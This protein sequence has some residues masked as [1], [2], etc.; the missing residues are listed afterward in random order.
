MDIVVDS[1]QGDGMLLIDAAICTP[2]AHSYL[3]AAQERGGAAGMRQSAKHSKYDSLTPEG[4]SFT[5]AVVEALGAWGPELEEYW[6]K[7]LAIME[8]E[9]EEFGEKH[10]ASQFA[11]RWL[12]RLSVSVQRGNALAIIHRCRRDRVAAGRSTGGRRLFSASQDDTY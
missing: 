5:A 8:K 12:P 3:E 2:M 7:I 10:I 9:A 6:K 4:S 1:A 11:N